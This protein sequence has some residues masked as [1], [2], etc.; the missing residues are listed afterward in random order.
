MEEKNTP[1]ELVIR[2]PK[3]LFTKKIT[4][5]NFGLKKKE[6]SI[7]TLVTK[8][9][10]AAPYHYSTPSSAN[11]FGIILYILIFVL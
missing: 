4:I 5:K 9:Q 2:K 11:V 3:R 10:A 8:N 6:W 1:A 7:R